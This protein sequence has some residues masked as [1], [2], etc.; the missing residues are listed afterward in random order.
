VVLV[1]SLARGEFRVGSDIDLAAEG[2]PV[3]S[4]FRAL[5]RLRM[6]LARIARTPSQNTKGE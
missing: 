5:R 6:K 1:G 2:I 4:L 3:G